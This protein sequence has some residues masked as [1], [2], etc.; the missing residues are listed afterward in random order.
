M[1]CVYHFLW[2]PLF[3]FL[4]INCFLCVLNLYIYIYTY[5]VTRISHDYTGVILI[6]GIFM[7]G[8]PKVM[9]FQE[10]QS[11]CWHVDKFLFPRPSRALRIYSCLNGR[12]VG[13]TVAECHVCR[14][15]AQWWCWKLFCLAKV[16]WRWT[17]H[18][19]MHMDTIRSLASSIWYS[20][21]VNDKSVFGPDWTSCFFF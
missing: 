19:M 21:P 16:L 9:V 8:I 11:S 7:L 5:W 4:D 6:W 15:L 20:A 12:A 3:T 13:R 18:A 2:P 14:W 17:F 1:Y 10:V